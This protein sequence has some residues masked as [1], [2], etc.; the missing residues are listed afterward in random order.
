MKKVLVKLPATLFFL[1][2]ESADVLGDCSRSAVKDFISG[3]VV[4][5]AQ[6]L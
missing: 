4:F 6:F 3:S 1:R 2:L 5:S